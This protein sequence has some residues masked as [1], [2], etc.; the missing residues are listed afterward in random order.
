M[1]S[2][3]KLKTSVNSKATQLKRYTNSTTIELEST[4]VESLIYLK[5]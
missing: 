4:K 1:S 5:V 3:S 2:V